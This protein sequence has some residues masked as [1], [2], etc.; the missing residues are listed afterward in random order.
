M[1][2][3]ERLEFAPPEGR[4]HQPHGA[5]VPLVASAND[6]T[7]R[8]G[9]I[10][11]LDGAVVPQEQMVRHRRDRRAEGVPVPADREEQLVLGRGQSL[12]T[13]SLGAPAQEP[14]KAVPEPQEL[15]VLPFRYLLGHAI[16]VS[17]HDTSFARPETKG[18]QR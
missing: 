3:R 11:E 7:G 17:H 1:Q 13:G 16:I 8:H 6:Q 4:E 15:L 9:P 10:D 12:R 18:G 2:L 14:A 5:S